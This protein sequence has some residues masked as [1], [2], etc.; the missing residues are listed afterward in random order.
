VSI[1]EAV[2]LRVAANQVLS[3]NQLV[4][5]GGVGT[6]ETPRLEFFQDNRRLA[7]LTKDGTIRVLDVEEDSPQGGDDR[8]ELYADG[9]LAATLGPTGLVAQQIEEV[10]GN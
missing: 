4:V 9:K 5:T 8:F 6:S 2:A 7:T 3:L 10:Y 1:Q